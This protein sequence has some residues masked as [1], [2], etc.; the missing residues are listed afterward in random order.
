MTF[1]RVAVPQIRIHVRT[2]LVIGLGIVIIFRIASPY[3]DCS[4]KFRR[5]AMLS[6]DI[7]RMLSTVS[8]S[9]KKWIENGAKDR[10]ATNQLVAIVI[11]LLELVA[12]QQ[13]RFRL[14]SPKRLNVGS[15]LHAVQ[16]SR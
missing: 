4:G 3:A 12:K 8:L 9:C 16:C 15:M 11:D 7:H 10:I 13:L 6:T 1:R 14:D 5:K 2:V